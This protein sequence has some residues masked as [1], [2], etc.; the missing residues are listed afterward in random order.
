MRE[1]E[2]GERG[3]PRND[4]RRLVWG[5]PLIPERATTDRHAGASQQ[6]D[7]GRTGELVKSRQET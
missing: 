5:S 3:D 6:T 7:V 1:R 4:H 2:K